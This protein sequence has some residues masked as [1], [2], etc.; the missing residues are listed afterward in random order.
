[1]TTFAELSFTVEVIDSVADYVE[2]LRRCF[3]FEAIRAF[4]TRGNFCM[5]FDSMNGGNGARCEQTKTAFG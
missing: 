2:V 3:D 1:M 4:V 5:L